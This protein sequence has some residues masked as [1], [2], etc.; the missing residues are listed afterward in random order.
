MYFFSVFTTTFLCIIQLLHKN[1]IKKGFWNM[2][3]MKISL[4]KSKP[5][6]ETIMN[7]I[8]TLLEAENINFTINEKKSEIIVEEG[9]EKVRSI[10]G[11]MDCP[12]DCKIV[13]LDIS[14]DD[15]KTHI[16]LKYA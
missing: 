7:D 4:E 11:E 10:I 12:S 5:Y 3:V 2:N 15:K 9:E 16:R 13:L 14:G 6:S 8:G 1:T